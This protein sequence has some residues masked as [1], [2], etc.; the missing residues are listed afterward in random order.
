MSCEGVA[1]EKLVPATGTP[2][3]VPLTG[4]LHPS[5]SAHQVQMGTPPKINDMIKISAG[6][7]KQSKTNHNWYCQ[8]PKF[9]RGLVPTRNFCSIFYE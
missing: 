7:E 5:T 8:S 3:R 1:F 2:K 4:V 6:D 9:R